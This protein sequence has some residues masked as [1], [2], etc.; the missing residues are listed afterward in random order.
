MFHHVGLQRH[1]PFGMIMLNKVLAHSRHCRE[2]TF[3]RAS[4]VGLFEKQEWEQILLGPTNF[5]RNTI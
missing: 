1:H 2:T 4:L 3:F 5:T